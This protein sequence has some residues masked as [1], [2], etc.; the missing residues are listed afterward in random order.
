MRYLSVLL[1]LGVT[2]KVNAQQINPVPDYVFRYQMSVGRNAATDTAAYFSIGP[3]FGATKGFQPP[4]VVDTATMSG[5]K[6]NGLTIFSVQK[7]KYVYWDSVGV[8]WAEMAGTAG[9]ALTTADT[10]NL[11]S[12]KAFRK[13]G[14]DS[15]ASIINTKTDTL[16]ISTR[17]W[18]QKG[19]DSLAAL[20]LS[21]SDTAT[22]LS[23]YTR[24]SG[25][26]GY[27]AR[28]RS[29]R[30]IDSSAIFQSG[31]NIGINTIN[32]SM[33]P[34][35]V[36]VRTRTPTRGIGVQ[37]TDFDSTTTTGSFMHFGLKAATGNSNATIESYRS[38]TSVA[39]NIEIQP[40]GG[41]V[42]INTSTDNGAY[43]LQVS[44]NVYATGGS[45]FN[46]ANT[47]ISYFG[48]TTA[49][50]ISGIAQ[51]AVQIQGNPGNYGGLLVAGQLSN[52]ANCDYI[53][54]I[55]SRG[56]TNTQLQFG[57]RL[58]GFMFGGAD[59]TN[60]LRSALIQASVD[61]V[62]GTNDMPG[63]IE[64]HTTQNGQ[65]VPTYFMALNNQGELIVQENPVDAGTY[66]LQVAGNIYSTGSIT[67]GAPTSGSIKPW[68]LG[69]VA[70]VS[71]TSP[72]RTIRV[73]IDGVVYFIH[74]KT[75]ND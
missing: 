54:F 47:T 39:N 21:L 64:F 43:A 69:E 29:T 14:D 17:A 2:L 46:A 40:L 11:L 9:N 3:R 55:K 27:M 23:P 15:L 59:G 20:E 30:Q 26:S 34:L 38:G 72:N 18:R 4:M 50:S 13:K 25:V 24:G 35:N 56:S 41:E 66:K 62:P 51:G 45:V 28:W 68:K 36:A 60:F 33:N 6:R 5:S 8:K 71:P 12:T 53:Q 19:L 63:R 65:S 70:T 37:S 1:L 48:T 75:T 31:Q 42:L 22:M 74:A 44:G 7:N 61:S 73:E 57:D 58:G 49:R 67:T 32:T 16:L 52:N 10:V